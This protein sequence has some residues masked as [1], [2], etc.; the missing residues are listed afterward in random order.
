MSS[1]Y[2]TP[3]TELPTLNL[4]GV[5]ND[6]GKIHS[7]HC[8]DLH[9]DKRRVGDLGKPV[10]ADLDRAG[11]RKPDPIRFHELVPGRKD[12]EEVRRQKLLSSVSLRPEAGEDKT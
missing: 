9:S 6:H 3:N 4:E 1:E 12:P 10:V 7:N 11:R 5:K 2:K 8:R